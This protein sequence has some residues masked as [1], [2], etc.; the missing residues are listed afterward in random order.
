[1]RFIGGPTDPCQIG[2]APQTPG[3][4]PCSGFT[5]T[6]IGFSTRS[7]R[8][9]PRSFRNVRDTLFGPSNAF[10]ETGPL[11]G[12]GLS[13][14][15]DAFTR[16]RTPLDRRSDRFRALTAPAVRLPTESA[17]FPL[18]SARLAAPKRSHSSPRF[19]M[20]QATPARLFHWRAGSITGNRLD[21]RC[22]GRTAR[23]YTATIELVVRRH[24]P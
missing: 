17:R 11:M 18:G 3:Q 8:D 19:A 7:A 1:M 12:K 16:H 21:V 20:G 9:R 22:K 6:E 13:W 15:H 24:V 2:T 14:R 23:A 10:R 4:A 5:R